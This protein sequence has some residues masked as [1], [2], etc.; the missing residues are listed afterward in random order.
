MLPTKIA[1]QA[2]ADPTT[3]AHR[4]YE[5]LARHCPQG[6]QKAHAFVVPIDAWGW[7]MVDLAVVDRLISRPPVAGFITINVSPET[8]CSAWAWPLWIEGVRRIVE[9]HQMQIAV[10][11]SERAVDVCPR[12]MTDRIQSLHDLGVPVGLDDLVESD[13][14]QVLNLYFRHSWDFVKI[15]WRPVTRG[16]HRQIAEVLMACRERS[17]STVL[18]GVETE[19]D[20]EC[21][22]NMGADLV[23]GFGVH[24][25]KIY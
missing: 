6:A 10:E 14:D 22:R 15:D 17:I 8:L 1:L 25:P 5:V 13:P 24:C 19:H 16:D 23:Q 21:A 11:I 9:P 12:T 2:L 20:L 4:G 18:E 3:L 7:W